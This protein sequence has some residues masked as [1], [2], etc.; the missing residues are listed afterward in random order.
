MIP[1][2]LAL[3]AAIVYALSFIFSKRGMHHSTPITVT[4][5]SL[6]IQSVVLSVIVIALTGIP[7]T[8]AF[9]LGSTGAF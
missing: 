9:V 7:S 6:L 3:L 2:S 4:F 8:P 5:V 1:Q